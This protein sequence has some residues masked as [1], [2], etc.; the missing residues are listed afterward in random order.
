M[1]TT[2]CKCS[3][4]NCLMEVT[5]DKCTHDTEKCQLI[6][7]VNQLIGFE[8]SQ[9]NFSDRACCRLWYGEVASSPDIFWDFQ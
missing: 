3:K 2:F 6:C 4:N 1:K 8:N 9:R 5:I 7:R